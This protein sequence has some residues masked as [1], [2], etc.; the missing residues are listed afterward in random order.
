MGN[1]HDFA[2]WFYDIWGSNNLLK[3]TTK[4]LMRN[5][6]STKIYFPCS[7]GLATMPMHFDTIRG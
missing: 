7:Y 1:A 4:E 6:E 2:L 5:F 3:D